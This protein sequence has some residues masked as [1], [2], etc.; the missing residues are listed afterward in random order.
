MPPMTPEPS[1]MSQSWC[2][3]IPTAEMT[4]P[5]HQ[6]NAATTPALRGPTRST[7]PPQIAAEEPR[8]MKKSIYIGA[9]STTRQSQLVV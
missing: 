1:H 8:K 2:K 5:P 3:M 6:Q 7:Q 9:R 4:N